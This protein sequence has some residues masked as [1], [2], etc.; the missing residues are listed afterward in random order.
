MDTP[1]TNL[2]YCSFA[3]G[4]VR[5]NRDTIQC[6]CVRVCVWRVILDCGD[7]NWLRLIRTLRAGITVPV[8]SGVTADHRSVLC[9]LVPGRSGST[10]LF[11]SGPVST[12][13]GN[14]RLS[15][16]TL[17]GHL[18]SGVNR[19]QKRVANAMWL[20][21]QGCAIEYFSIRILDRVPYRI[22]EYNASDVTL[23]SRAMTTTVTTSRDRKSISE[24]IY[25]ASCK[26]T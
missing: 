5:V 17:T 23:T 24:S 26:T 25:L 9:R 1:I 22:L 12:G 11:T 19:R 13:M 15:G 2:R 4:I 14:R 18:S 7:H 6:A 21:S 20:F 3:A 8:R 16:Y 10:K